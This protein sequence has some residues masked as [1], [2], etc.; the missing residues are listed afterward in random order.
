[1]HQVCVF[2]Q[3]VSSYSSVSLVALSYLTTF[4]RDVLLVDTGIIY[5]HSLALAQTS[6]VDDNLHHCNSQYV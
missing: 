5:L 4:I 6:K 2:L 3:Y 1:M